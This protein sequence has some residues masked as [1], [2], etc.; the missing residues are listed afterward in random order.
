M[1]A[2]AKSL[3][4]AILSVRALWALIVPRSSIL[5]GWL[6]LGERLAVNVFILMV[7]SGPRLFLLSREARRTGVAAT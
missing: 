4:A 7:P 1:P 5:L 2:A 3:S 6:I